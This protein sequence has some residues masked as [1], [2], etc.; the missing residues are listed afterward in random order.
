MKPIACARDGGAA[1]PAHLIYLAVFLALPFGMLGCATDAGF[2]GDATNGV[3]VT[4]DR[5]LQQARRDLD[6]GDYAAAIHRLLGVVSHGVTTPEA[7]EARF[8]LAKAHMETGAYADAREQ[9]LAYL[10]QAPE[11]PGRREAEAMLAEVE[12]KTGE[13][14]VTDAELAARVEAAQTAVKNGPDDPAHWLKLGDLQW[15]RGRYAD[16]AASYE[17]VI[18]RWPAY[19]TRPPISERMEL[20]DDGRYYPV[21]PAVVTERMIKA[22]PLVVYGV[23]TYTSGKTGWQDQSYEDAFYHVTGIVK[24]RGTEKLTRVAVEVRLYGAVANLFD[25]K[26]YTIGTLRPGAERAFSLRFEN[27]DN[28]HNVSRHEIRT[29]YRRGGGR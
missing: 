27:F 4:P 1:V 29:S 26:T 24:N 12:A 10:R 7:R 8:L 5:V 21:T 2:G 6:A 25:A 3:Y 11:G 16:A 23:N 17:E 9:L 18:S 20:G 13:H 19:T 22:E 15:K 14:H 28:I